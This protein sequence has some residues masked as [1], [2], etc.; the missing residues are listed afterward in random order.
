MPER[1]AQAHWEGQEGHGSVTV[2]SGGFESDY[3][4][5][6][7]FENGRGT[8]PEEL[9]GAAHAGC[10]TTELALGLSEAG[11]PTGT[12]QHGSPGEL[13]ERVASDLGTFGPGVFARHVA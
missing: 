10:F 2:E 7:R 12:H 3:S 6:S 8:N 11:H 5:G 1:T 4:S 13:A 9:L